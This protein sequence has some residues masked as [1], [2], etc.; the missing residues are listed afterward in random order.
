[1]DGTP[2]TFKT[3]TFVV[4]I[5]ES[6]FFSHRESVDCLIGAA[7]AAAG[8][9]NV[10]VTRFDSQVP[11]G[12]ADKLRSKAFVQDAKIDDDGV[13][14][15]TTFRFTLELFG[16]TNRPINA[17]LAE[18]DCQVTTRNGKTFDKLF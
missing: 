15:Q 2:T 3:T 16:N 1:M 5:E 10:L 11:L 18:K 6:A 8:V 17:G 14:L 4:D 12:V 13:T 9:K 7:M